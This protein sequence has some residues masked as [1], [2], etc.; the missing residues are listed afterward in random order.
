MGFSAVNLVGAPV[1][2]ALDSF[3]QTAWEK[4]SK[5]TGATTAVADQPTNK[6]TTDKPVDNTSTT[7]STKPT[8]KKPESDATPTTP[9]DTAA[10]KVD[11]NATPID[12]WIN[13]GGGYIKDPATG[14]IK[15][16]VARQYQ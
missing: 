7:Q 5:S 2:S 12:K 11:P 1:A 15:R 3:G 4:A 6:P 16:S 14:E 8:E 10:P 13:L 9:A